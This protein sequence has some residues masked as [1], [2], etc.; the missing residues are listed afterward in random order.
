MHMLCICQIAAPSMYPTAAAFP[1]PEYPGPHSFMAYA[2]VVAVI[3]GFLNI[4][5]LFFTIPALECATMVSN[6]RQYRPP[7]LR[8]WTGDII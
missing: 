8:G 6:N 2:I 5:S 7:A 1:K 4:F 3:T